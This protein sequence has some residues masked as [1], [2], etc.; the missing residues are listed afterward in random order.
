[1]N[2]VVVLKLGKGQQIYPVILPLANEQLKVLFKFLVDAFGL[3]ISLRVIGCSG[4]NLD[5]EQPIEFP[6]EL[7]YKLRPSVGND[8]SR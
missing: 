2:V 6:S 4:C 8:P 1:V 7:G 3:S 5:A